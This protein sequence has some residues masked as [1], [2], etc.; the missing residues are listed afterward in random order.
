[1]LFGTFSIKHWGLNNKISI[2]Q[3]KF[4]DLFV[5]NV[6]FD[7]NFIEVWS[8]S[9]LDNYESLFHITWANLHL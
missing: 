6:Y 8:L 7:S 2:S 1:M 4:S 9:T 3:I 5:E